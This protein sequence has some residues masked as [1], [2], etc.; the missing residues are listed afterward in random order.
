M[1]LVEHFLKT[2]LFP[3]VEG[4]HLLGDFLALLSDESLLKRKDHSVIVLHSRDGLDAVVELAV[5][6]FLGLAL[7]LRQQHQL[8][9]VLLESLNV[10]LERLVGL[11]GPSGVDV[12]SN[13]AGEVLVESNSLDLLQSE[14]S[15][16]SYLARVSLSRLVNDRLEMVQRPGVNLG[17]ARLSLLQPLQLLGGLVEERSDQRSWVL[18]QMRSLNGV[19]VSR[20]DL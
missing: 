8:V 14:P 2:E 9:E 7:F 4:V 6:S 13:R 5:A 1:L 11:V 19:V 16:Q 20:H 18:A 10:S 17:S 15:S 3:W 12:D